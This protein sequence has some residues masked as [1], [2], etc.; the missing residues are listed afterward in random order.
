M[1]SLVVVACFAFVT[2]ACSD[3]AAKETAASAAP[4][5]VAVVPAGPLGD[6]LTGY[7]QLRAA[8]ANDDTTPVAALAT[9]LE[10]PAAALAEAKKPGADDLVKAVAALKAAIDVKAAR[11]AFGDLS[12]GVV[13]AVAADA[14]LQPGR[15][16]FSCPM[17]AGYQQWVQL[18]STMANPYMGKRM[19]G[20]GEA[21]AAW[22]V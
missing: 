11:L 22:K 7:E 18:S 10:A 5:V 3:A 20:C 6:V 14:T 16:L 4:A 17:A 13:A 1:R 2:A 12:R 8:L 21:K 9:K 15:F 19:L